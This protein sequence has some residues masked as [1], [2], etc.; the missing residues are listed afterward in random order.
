MRA[1]IQG[2]ASGGVEQ[3]WLLSALLSPATC[4]QTGL[5]VHAHW[6]WAL[7]LVSG[8]ARWDGYLDP[9]A[10]GGQTHIAE[11]SGFRV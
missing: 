8:V 9:C 1:Y 3:H 5:C 11:L 7:K 2:A 10:N 6:V 4:M